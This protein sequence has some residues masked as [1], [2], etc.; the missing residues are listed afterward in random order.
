MKM[1]SKMNTYG[2]RLGFDHNYL[3]RVKMNDPIIE[4]VSFE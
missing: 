2:L 1:T 3:I 4:K